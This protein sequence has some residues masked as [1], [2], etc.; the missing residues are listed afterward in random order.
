MDRRREMIESLEKA[1]EAIALSV[2]TSLAVVFAECEEYELTF[3]K[4]RNPSRLAQ[5][6]SQAHGFNEREAA[7][8]FSKL[9]REIESLATS[10]RSLIN[11]SNQ[12]I[13][14]ISEPERGESL[15]APPVQ[16]LSPTHEQKKQK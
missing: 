10:V 3:T 15:S 8:A 2:N 11:F 14:R 6:V 7:E 9:R 12:L 1:A 16:I 4:P 13:S 5:G